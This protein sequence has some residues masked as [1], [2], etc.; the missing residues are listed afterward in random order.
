[1]S[2]LNLLEWKIFNRDKLTFRNFI[3]YQTHG[4]CKKHLET[5][6][7]KGKIKGE[8]EQRKKHFQLCIELKKKDLS[9][10]LK[11]KLNEIIYV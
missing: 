6:W 4:H 5:A 7:K 1:M 8:C 3:R 10:N 9:E 2:K 11:S